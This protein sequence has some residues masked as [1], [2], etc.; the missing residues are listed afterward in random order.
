M[1]HPARPTEILSI[2]VAIAVEIADVLIPVV[3]ILSQIHPVF[4]PRALILVELVHI[5]LQLFGVAG[6]P[7]LANLLPVLVDL[8]LIPDELSL[9]LIDLVLVLVNLLPVLT[10]LLTILH[11]CR[12]LRMMFLPLRFLF[13]RCVLPTLC[14]C[15]KLFSGFGMVR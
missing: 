2:V 4:M 7:I 13:R 11:E 14:G 9:I 15:L 10:D 5:F 6:S 1:P 3:P 12:G 8:V